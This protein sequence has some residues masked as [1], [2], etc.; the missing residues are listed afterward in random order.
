[1]IDNSCVT[2]ENGVKY[3]IIDIIKHDK[4]KYIY[5]MAIDNEEDICCRKE[6]VENNENILI[7]LD[8]EEEFNL[9]LKLFAEKHTKD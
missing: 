1:M 2:L 6:I 5:L 8:N 4:I 7:G 9:A 3:Q